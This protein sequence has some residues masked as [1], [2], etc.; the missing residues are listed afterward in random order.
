MYLWPTI[1]AGITDAV[2]DIVGVG[3]ELSCFLRWLTV[4]MRLVLSIP[5]ERL[6]IPIAI[7][8]IIIV[9]LAFVLVTL[10]EPDS[11][12]G[13]FTLPSIRMHLLNH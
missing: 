4:L 10:S 9:T 6:S 13:C 11:M 5:W 3:G 7:G 2:M 8:T 12:I 1:D